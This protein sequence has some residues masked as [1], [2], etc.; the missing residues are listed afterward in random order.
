METL[1]DADLDWLTAVENR[2]IRLRKR[3]AANAARLD[4]EIAD[5]IAAVDRLRVM[6]AARFGR[7]VDHLQF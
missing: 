6:L 1:N 3:E 7:Q 4:P 2:V 5:V